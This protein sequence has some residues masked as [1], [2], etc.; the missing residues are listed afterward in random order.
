MKGFTTLGFQELFTCVKVLRKLLCD[1]IV[2]AK[3]RT[4]EQ[5][6]V[7]DQ[8]WLV[9]RNGLPCPVVMM[10][11]RWVLM[12]VLYAMHVES[13]SDKA[14]LSKLWAAAVEHHQSNRIEAAI[15]VQCQLHCST[16]SPPY[17]AALRIGLSSR[18]PNLS[19]YGQTCVLE[20]SCPSFTTG[21]RDRPCDA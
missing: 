16:A 19:W 14:S 2:D 21:K 3:E 9:R 10:A 13:N 15:L 12:W 20:R 18:D 5:Q 11:R 1:G 7:H 8:V 4:F 6:P 17:Q